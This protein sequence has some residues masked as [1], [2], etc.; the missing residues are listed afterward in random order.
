M[1]TKYVVSFIVNEISCTYFANITEVHL[2]LRLHVKT[3]I[4]NKTLIK[5]YF[6]SLNV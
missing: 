1:Y 6:E 4:R 3:I 5:K 2:I